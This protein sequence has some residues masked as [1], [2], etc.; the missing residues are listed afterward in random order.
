M[1]PRTHE[2]LCGIILLA[3][4]VGCG[5]SAGGSVGEKSAKDAVPSNTYLEVYAS[6]QNMASSLV[7]KVLAREGSA[8]GPVLIMDSGNVL[9]VTGLGDLSHHA[10]DKSEEFAPGGTHY[11]LHLE[12][13]VKNEP[14]ELVWKRNGVSLATVALPSAKLAEVKSFAEC[15]PILTGAE[16]SVVRF[17]A[18]ALTKSDTICGTIVECS[19]KECLRDTSCRI[20]EDEFLFF[21]SP[22]SNPD[23]VRA[24]LT[25]TNRQDSVQGFK[26]GKI[27]SQ[28]DTGDVE[29]KYDQKCPSPI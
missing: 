11:E 10:W 28:F 7:V 8:N 5:K 9:S 14:Y 20:F 22:L 17:A 26:S 13:G 18:D 19:T 6:W 24:R 4:C 15:V 23:N 25:R 3:A 16:H 12:N 1:R 27:Y 2:E 29:P 21:E